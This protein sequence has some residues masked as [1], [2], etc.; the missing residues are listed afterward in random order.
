MD[1]TASTISTPAL[2]SPL[3]YANDLSYVRSTYTTVAA[4]VIVRFQKLCGHFARFVTRTD[5]HGQT[6]QRPVEQLGR[7]PKGHSDQ[8]AAGFEQFWHLLNIQSDR[9]IRTADPRQ[10]TIIQV[11]FQRVWNKGDIDLGQQTG[12]CYVSC[13][14]FKEERLASEQVLYSILTPVRLAACLSQSMI[15]SISN[16][17]YRQLRL[18][19]AFNQSQIPIDFTFD[20]Q[21]QRGILEEGHPLKTAEP[22]L[23]NSEA[24]KP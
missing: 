16:A 15:P 13:E 1:N 5:E 18:S 7:S 4:N 12:W 22:I 8:V 9:F 17:I 3:C 10:Q 24:P 14:G 21:V 11:F 20:P 23:H 19:F 2:A 6:I